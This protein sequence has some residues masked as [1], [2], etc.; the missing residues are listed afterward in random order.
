MTDGNAMFLRQMFK[1]CSIEHFWQRQPQGESE[2]L[3]CNFR[4]IA[5]ADFTAGSGFYPLLL[6]DLLGSAAV[7]QFF[8]YFAVQ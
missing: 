4:E 1:V 2:C 7:N 6:Y 8:G 3:G 5:F